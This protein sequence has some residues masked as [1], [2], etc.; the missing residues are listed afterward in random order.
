VLDLVAPDGAAVEAGER[1]VDERW[2][3]PVDLPQEPFRVAVT[4][5]D[6]SGKQYQRSR[7][8]WTWML[9]PSSRLPSRFGFR[10]ASP[11]AQTSI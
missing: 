4:G 2:E 11:P 10:P 6:Q 1:V 7:R 9:A 8:R 3:G 5:L